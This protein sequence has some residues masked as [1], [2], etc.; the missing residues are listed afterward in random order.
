M[1]EQ[2]GATSAPEASGDLPTKEEIAALVPEVAGETKTETPAENT[3]QAPEPAAEAKKE[4]TPTAREGTPDKALQKLQQDLG[5]ATR[6]IEELTAKLQSGQ[7]LTTAERQQVQQQQRKVDALKAKL[8]GNQFNIVDDDALLADSVVEQDERLASL[9]RQNAELKARLDA[10]E[11]RTAETDARSADAAIRAKYPDVD[12]GPIWEKCLAE[13]VEV[14]GE[15]ANRN[16]IQRLADRDFHQRCD[17]AQ[18]S[19]AAKKGATKPTPAVPPK[20]AAQARVSA[21]QHA[22]YAEPQGIDQDWAATA[23]ELGKVLSG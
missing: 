17:A 9:E 6:K 5:V 7:T 4:E 10:T 14:L 15:D 1:T 23:A 22:P 12:Y 11:R 13:A 19:I 20:L 2:S 18:K 21:Q 3:E 16:A 8:G